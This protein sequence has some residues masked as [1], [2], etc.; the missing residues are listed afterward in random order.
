MPN[1]PNVPSPTLPKPS[2]NDVSVTVVDKLWSGDTSDITKTCD[3]L[4][5][6]PPEFTC[7]S[8]DVDDTDMKTPEVN[9]T[10]DLSKSVSASSSAPE[11]TGAPKDKTPRESEYTVY[12]TSLSCLLCY[13]CESKSLFWH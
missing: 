13:V 12:F 2:L 3:R 1:V 5:D 9:T 7:V 4:S 10:S 8:D 6:S 11:L